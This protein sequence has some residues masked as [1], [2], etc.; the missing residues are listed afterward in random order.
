MAIAAV[1]A[2]T[3]KR[4]SFLLYGSDAGELYGD[5]LPEEVATDPVADLAYLH[6]KLVQLFLDPCFYSL[7]S[8]HEYAG[9]RAAWRQPLSVQLPALLLIPLCVVGRRLARRPRGAP[10]AVIEAE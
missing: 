9:I 8:L 4:N 1:Y 7:C 6:L 2:V 10:A 3:G 5:L